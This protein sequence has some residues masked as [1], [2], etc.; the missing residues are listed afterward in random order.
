MKSIVTGAAGFIGS[1]IADKLVALGHEVVAIDNLCNGSPDNLAQASVVG[2]VTLVQADVADYPAIEPHFA[3]ADHVYHLAGMAD[4]VPSIENP[5][6]YHHANVTGT[7]NVLEAAR[8]HEARRFI[9]AASSSCYGIPKIYPTPESATI[10]PMYPYSLTKQLGEAYMLHW[11]KTYGLP[12]LSLRLF[13]VY[14]P[15]G[16]TQGAYGAVFK[17]FLAQK[18]AGKP[19]TVVGDGEQTRDFVY[20]SDV[21]E[22][23]VAAGY[24]SLSG[25]AFNVGTGQPQSVNRLV[26]LLGGDVVHIPD[27][28][29]E[30]R[31]THADI[32]RI[33]QA[34]G[35]EPKVSFEEGVQAM[36]DNIEFW[37]DAP[38]WEEES[39]ARATESWFKYLS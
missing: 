20:V 22:A 35:W 17:V 5:L 30:P 15:R 9:Y 3:G 10:Q 11:E 28:P 27:R 14:G 21:A 32:S 8:K 1:H 13:N 2:K 31:S 7:V 29:G 18:L 23:F 12:C 38:V 16:R 39:I 24:S 19:F 34:L 4:I 6:L 33:R 25:E 26:E 37:R 36:L